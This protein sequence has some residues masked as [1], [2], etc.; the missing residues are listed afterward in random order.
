V[1]GE[2]N[3]F[4]TGWVTYF[5]HAACKRHLHRLDEWIRRKLRCL[6]LTQR[7]RA[8]PIAEFLHQLGVPKWRAWIGALSGKGWWRLSGI[9]P[10]TEGMTL[11]WLESQGLVTKVTHPWNPPPPRRAGNARWRSRRELKRKICV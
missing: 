5:C 3:L 7:K 1:I 11:A 2:L 9:P 8:G 10:V 6:R 4:L